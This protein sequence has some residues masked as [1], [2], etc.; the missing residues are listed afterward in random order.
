MSLS[1]AT[2]WHKASYERFLNERLPELLTERLPLAGYRV[3]DESP[4]TCSL[5]VELA[6][7]VC[8]TYAAIPHPDEN[9]IF[10]L[11]GEPHVIVPT[12]SSEDLDSAEIA[13]VGEQLYDF[14]ASAL[15]QTSNGFAWDEALLRAWLPLDRWI[16]DFLHINGQRLDTTNWLCRHT[17]PRRLL[18]PNRQRVIA[19]G[20]FGRVC[21]YE[22]PE[23]PNIGRVFTVSVGAE[24]RDGKLV[25]TD[26]RPAAGLGLSASML[27]FLEHNDPNRL[28]F[29]ANFQRQ[30]IPAP[31]PEPALVLTGNEP[32]AAPDFWCG[33]N[34]L[35]AFISLGAATIE[36][37]IVIS[38]SAAQRLNFP[39]P[40]EPGDKL[41][42][43]HGIVGVVSQVLP[44]DEMPHLPNGQPVELVCSFTSLPTRLVIGPVLEA[45]WGMVAVA[46]S[47]SAVAEG[48]SIT[49]PPL[50]APSRDELAA[51]L[52]SA[53]LP[54]AG[55]QLLTLGKDGEKLER[56]S[57]V[58]WVYW[59]RS[60]HL[61]R[62]RLG[63]FADGQP[64]SFGKA[65]FAALFTAGAMENLREMVST[66]AL[67]HPLA[68]TLPERLAV[69]P[70]EQA[71]APTWCFSDLVDRLQAAGIAASLQDGRLHFRLEAPRGE[72]LKL[73]RPLPHP[74]L[75]GY[76]L[77]AVGSQPDLAEYTRLVEAN[78]RL[79]KLLDGASPRRLV[80]EA[81]RSLE[82]CLKAFL[83][84]LLPPEALQWQGQV[85]FS[86]H[87]VLAPGEDLRSD[88]VG[89]P[90]TLA[91]ALFTP[92]VKRQHG[93]AAARD[94]QAL[95]DVMANSWVLINS[96]PNLPP[97]T[98]LAFRPLRVPDPAIRLHPLACVLLNADFNGD[99]AT[100]HLPV[101]DAAQR[102]AGEKLTIAAHV[103]REPSLVGHLLP[104]PDVM[105]GLSWLACQ[106][107]GKAQLAETLALEANTLPD[108]LTTTAV[109]EL[110][111]Q[112]VQ[113]DGVDV[114]LERVERLAA[115]AYDA[116]RQSGASLSPMFGRGLQLPAMPDGDDLTEWQLYA[117]KQAE[118]M[119]AGTDYADPVNGPQLLAAK[120]RPRNR[121]SLPAL[122]GLRGL[123]PAAADGWVAI[124]HSQCE[125]LT[126]AE[127]F[128]VVAG[129]RRGLA[130]VIN[131]MEQSGPSTPE[132][133]CWTVL[134]RAR[135]ARHPGVIFARAAASGEV[136]PLTDLESR[137]FVGLSA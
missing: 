55:Q 36:D 30:S 49:V 94:P 107:Q 63:S 42:N 28:L 23:S 24:I 131:R 121:R 89:L 97:T 132:T 48:Q 40:A 79:A 66:R 58:G 128:G 98:M 18:I 137:L 32:Q 57:T 119:L 50:A 134:A 83:A 4:S 44:D 116:V 62:P 39:Y 21:P 68:A 86:A 117:E 20:Q 133:S 129:A 16:G 54:E 123:A 56:P 111:A 77:E 31:D 46:E 127:T 11:K 126:P 51:R 73:A 7:G 69:G 2:P 52:Q 22:T 91:W 84:A 103:R 85:S 100:V 109:G 136:D 102:E 106:P 17:H 1:T 114:T 60:A 74:W 88:Q 125:G 8:A 47:Q 61:A 95:D 90:E 104:N 67:G 118:A 75:D 19:P 45:A 65:E 115:L 15:G 6:G 105:W 35:T 29:A 41:S 26:D 33:R 5:Q 96:S 64:A 80:L 78:Q 135:A 53:G 99:Q 93:A 27:P 124:R 120:T 59:N 92:L 43:R 37:G 14:I 82:K 76:A 122:A 87:A 81:E 71:A 13:C 110:L 101:T 34:L 130:D 113:R 9:G 10:T 70:V 38:Q 3:L 72:A 108:L 112:I 12:A 25:I